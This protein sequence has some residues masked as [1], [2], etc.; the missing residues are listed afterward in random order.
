MVGLVVHQALH[1]IEWSE[2]VWKI[3]APDMKAMS[4]FDRVAFQ[5]IVWTGED[6]FVDLKANNTVFGLYTH[7]ARISA[8]REYLARF[9]PKVVSLDQLVFHWWNHLYADLPEQ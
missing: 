2:H 7:P 6:I 8:L 9:D 4:P 1:N 5:K 3:L